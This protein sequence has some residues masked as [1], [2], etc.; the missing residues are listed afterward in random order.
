MKNVLEDAELQY[1]HKPTDKPVTYKTERSRPNSALTYIR[2]LLANGFR[3]NQFYFRDDDRRLILK[4]WEREGLIL[5]SFQRRKFLNE[6]TS[7]DTITRRR[8]ELRS[9]FPES[10]EV[11][12]K[13]YHLF[14][15]EKEKH[16]KGGRLS[17]LFA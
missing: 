9:E 8:R 12:Q 7:P 2:S 1:Q 11:E 4:V 3:G 17:R 6:V 10:P 5:D 14:V 15:Q 13:R 16:S